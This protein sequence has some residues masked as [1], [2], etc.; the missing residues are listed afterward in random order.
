MANK[1]PEA[2]LAKN[3]LYCEANWDK[4]Y[5]KQLEWQRNNKDKVNTANRK[6]RKK[7]RAE[8]LEAYGSICSCCK[9]SCETFLEVDHINGGGNQHR[10]ELGGGAKFYAWLKS[11]GF[12]KNFRLLCSNCNKAIFKLGYCPHEREVVN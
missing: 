11:N 7:L 8:I 12:P 6:A 9:E 3:R 2:K 4:I 5:T 10:R 1:T